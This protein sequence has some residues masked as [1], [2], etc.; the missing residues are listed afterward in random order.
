M[1]DQACQEPNAAVYILDGEEHQVKIPEG[2]VKDVAAWIENG[3]WKELA[4]LETY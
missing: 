2:K 3:E 4:K 1:D